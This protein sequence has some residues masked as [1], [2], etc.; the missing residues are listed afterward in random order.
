MDQLFFLIALAVFVG[1]VSVTTALN[2]RKKAAAAPQAAPVAAPQQT[3]TQSLHRLAGQ[4]EQFVENSSHPREL[5]DQ[6]D[7]KAAAE[8][9]GAKDVGFEQLRQYALGATGRSPASP[10]TCSRSRAGTTSS[11]ARRSRN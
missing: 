4:M 2:R 7:F 10:F 6:P 9:L 8:L 3:T 1:G 5:L 11:P